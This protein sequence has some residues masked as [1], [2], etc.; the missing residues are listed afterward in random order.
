MEPL[1]SDFAALGLLDIC[2]FPT[3][4]KTESVPNL[5]VEVAT[6]L[7][8]RI[9]I[10]DIVT[11][12]SGE[13]QAHANTIGAE[14]LHQF[15]R[16]GRVAE[17]FR[18]LSAELVAHDTGEIDIA[19]RHVAIILISRHNHSGNPE[20]DDIG[21]GY[22]VGSGIIVF[23]FVVSGVVD[24]IEKRDGPQPRREPSV[25]AVAVLAQV[26][27]CEV[28]VSAL[29]LGERERLVGSLGN[30]ISALWEE[31]GRDAVSP[32][33]LAADTPVLD[34][35]HP[36]AIGVLVFRRIEFQF[37]V[38]HG[39]EGNLGKM[40]HLQ[41]PLHRE[42]RL[43]SHICSLAE[44]HLVGVRLNLFNQALLLQ[45]DFDLLAHIEAVHA[46]IE[47]S[48]LVE[49]AVIVEDVD[50]LEVVFLAEHIVVDIVSRSYFKTAGTK[51]D[52]DIFVFDHR[53]YTTHERHHHL[54]A[55]Q[56]AVLGVFGVDTHSGIAHDGFWAGSSHNGIAATLLID[57]N[58]LA[59]F[60]LGGGIG[61]VNHI[62]AEIIEFAMLLF[63]DHLLVAQSGESLGFPV[64]HA[65]T[66]VD[67][68]LVVQ[69]DKHLDNALAAGF[70]HGE[71][72]AVPVARSAELAQ[73]LEDDATVL[74][75]PRPGVLEELLAG[76]VGLFDALRGEFVHHLGFGGD[77]SVVGTGHPESI[78]ALHARAADEDILDCVVE[79][80]PHVKHT[81]Y[82]RR[83]DNDSVGFALIGNRF[84][85]L[86]VQP[87]FI[88]LSLNL[89][90]VVLG[91]QF[92]HICRFNKFL[93]P[94]CKVTQ[95]NAITPL[96]FTKIGSL[97]VKIIARDG[98][99]RHE[100]AF[101]VMGWGLA[102]IIRLRP[103]CNLR[104]QI[105]PGQPL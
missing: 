71:S 50:A 40:F 7:A 8:K 77:R 17:R 57:M 24:A 92:V 70:I 97:A 72:G 41:E 42:F 5:V 3:F 54:F 23:D 30:D 96:I 73:L 64:Y 89:G 10:E 6:L 56:P 100:A 12:R 94:N 93:I 45:V 83:R 105:C 1:H 36:V 55:A 74:L 37:I 35:L 101:F 15:N 98:K 62:V 11:G 4:H 78:L 79:H 13:H 66:A 90:G 46:H 22:E 87:I 84:K 65:H 18:H 51:F 75:G 20:E 34:I 63:I 25:E 59:L 82:I 104:I 88:P 48:L 26:V 14:T 69:I 81:G 76:E 2:H 53:D 9:V 28:A 58:H 29:F 39:S 60:R 19:E 44:A 27:D 47:H 43:D 33:E 86:V 49:S 61:V 21:T 52:I 99:R 68:A 67:Q 32:P 16:V 95:K 31:I 102:G 91:C 38:H 85:Q 103:K 80:V